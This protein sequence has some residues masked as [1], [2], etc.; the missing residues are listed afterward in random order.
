MRSSNEER[1]SA[2][3]A[4]IFTDPKKQKS[5][6]WLVFPVEMDVEKHENPTAN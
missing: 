2:R 5:I 4:D 1:K 6:G 3:E